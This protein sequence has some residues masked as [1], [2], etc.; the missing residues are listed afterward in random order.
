MLTAG[1]ALDRSPRPHV[2]SAGEMMW[3][4]PSAASPAGAEFEAPSISP[5]AAGVSMEEAAAAVS[6]EL[7]FCAPPILLC[8]LVDLLTIVVIW[9]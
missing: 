5:L 4:Y 2:P 9:T 7:A 3:R 6:L 8:E 1:V